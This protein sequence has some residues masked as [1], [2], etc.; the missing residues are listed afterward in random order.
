MSTCWA[1]PPA[2]DALPT[3]NNDNTRLPAA[4]AWR[5]AGLLPAQPP[6]PRQPGVLKAPRFAEGHGGQLQR[7]RDQR[8][9]HAVG[10]GVPLH[11]VLGGDRRFVPNSGHIQGIL[12]PP[13]NPKANYVELAPNSSPRAWYYDANHV[14][15]SWWPRWLEWIQQR[16]EEHQRET[17]T[18]WATRI[19]HRWKRRPGTYVRVRCA[20]H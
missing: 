1:E 2:F 6:G 7:G 10:R 20:V 12:N 13:G 11:R 4:P 5:P 9:H 16:S 15:G 3:W 14:E 8:P 17:L 18:A 19:T